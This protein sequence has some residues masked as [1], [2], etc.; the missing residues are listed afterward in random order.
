MACGWWSAKRPKPLVEK[1]RFSAFLKL[2]LKSGAG[3]GK[4]RRVRPIARIILERRPSC[5]SRSTRSGLAQ[6]DYRADKS[7]QTRTRL[8]KSQRIRKFQ[9]ASTDK[10]NDDWPFKKSGCREFLHFQK[11]DGPQ[12]AQVAPNRASKRL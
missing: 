12:T 9:C 5:C 8:A 1:A 11:G 4:P 6:T 10:K 3:V 7:R 2:L